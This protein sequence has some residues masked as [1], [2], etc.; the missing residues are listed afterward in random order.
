MGNLRVTESILS[1]ALIE[2]EGVL[3]SRALTQ[4]SSDPGNLCVLTPNHFLLERSENQIPPDVFDDLEINS[5]RRWRQSQVVADRI[6]KRW[7][8]EYLQ[9]LTTRQKWTS[10]EPSVVE[11]NLVLLEDVDSLRKHWEMAL[12]VEILPG[13]DG[14]VHA[15]K[16]K[17]WHNVFTRPVTNLQF[18]RR[19]W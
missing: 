14:R 6:N 3:I 19:M 11:G 9:T 16:V 18:W 10:D 4:A 7:L 2:T 15:V 8:Q 1:M 5:R 12:V 13:H 17:S